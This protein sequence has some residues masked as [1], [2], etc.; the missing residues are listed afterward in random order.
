MPIQ[1]NGSFHMKIVKSHCC[2][3]PKKGRI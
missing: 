3:G 1:F 2:C